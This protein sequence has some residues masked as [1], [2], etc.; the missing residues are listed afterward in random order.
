M[1]GI[2]AV[3]SDPRTAVNVDLVRPDEHDLIYQQRCSQ[4]CCAQLK[5]E[6]ASA[7]FGL[8]YSQL[9]PVFMLWRTIEGSLNRRTVDNK[10]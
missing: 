7:M 3:V 6:I 9:S 1:V 10:P 8:S 2:S 4:D 5:G